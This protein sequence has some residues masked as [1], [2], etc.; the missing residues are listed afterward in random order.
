MRWPGA[1]VDCSPERLQRALNILRARGDRDQ[2]AGVL[3]RCL[4]RKILGFF[5]RV[6]RGSPESDDLTQNVFLNVFMRGSKCP[7]DLKG[8]EAYLLKAARNEYIG[9]MRKRIVQL[10]LEDNAGLPE[11]QL[12]AEPSQEEEAIRHQRAQKVKEAIDR[13]SPGQR[14]CIMLHYEGWKTKEIAGLR[15]RT[16]GAVKALLHQG[17]KRLRLFLE[18]DFDD[19]DVREDD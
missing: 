1:S 15:G 16:E 9:S 2:G 14:F 3:W 10:S 8:F 4:Y 18:G 11:E 17:L 13:L 7:E 5:L 6:S 19:F 12:L